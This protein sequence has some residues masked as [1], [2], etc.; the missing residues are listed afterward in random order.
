PLARYGR[1]LVLVWPP[2]LLGAHVVE[3]VRTGS[4]AGTLLLLGVSAAFVATILLHHRPWS[5][6]PAPYGPTAGLVLQAALSALALAGAPDD[7]TGLAFVLLPLLVIAIG[8]VYP[9]RAPTLIG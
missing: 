1:W 3:A 2:L 4:W 5:G 8:V 9:Q 6:E 7:G